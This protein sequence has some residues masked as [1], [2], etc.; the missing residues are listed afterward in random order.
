MRKGW[1]VVNSF[2]NWDKFKELYSMLCDAARL[3]SINLK[4]KPSYTLLC[5]I[6]R[7]SFIIEQGEKPD[8][9]IFWD[10]DII[11][12]KALE[13]MGFRLFNSAEAIEL[14]ADKALTHLKLSKAGI[15]Q[16]KTVSAPKAYPSTKYNDL[17]FVRLAAEELGF[18][19]IIKERSGSFGFQ[20]HLAN[21]LSEAEEIVKSLE[22]KPL[23]L[24]E[25]I[26]SSR[27]RDIR[28]N[29][30][31]GKVESAMLRYSTNGDFRSNLTL[32]GKAEK[33]DLNKEQKK[34]A[35]DAVKSLGLDF[36][37]VDMLFG[38]SGEPIIC[39]VNSNAHF[40]TTLQYTG[41]NIAEKIIEMIV[42]R[43]YAHD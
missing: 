20:V 11:L 25:M 21:N 1:L 9:I 37:G 4:V 13:Q 26:K 41:V 6:T 31:D 30:V 35:L 42:I 33:Y 22:W 23:I 10:K 40:K 36:A 5:D 39:E 14:C 29:V 2:T 3:H 38:E 7:G 24:Q 16:P 27:G 28:I 18:P 34:A 15:R 19:L 8:F 32:G 17:S 43:I 12:A